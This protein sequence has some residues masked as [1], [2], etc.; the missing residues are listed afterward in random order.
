MN[1]PRVLEK[2]RS[3][4]NNEIKSIIECHDLPLY[5]MMRYHLGWIDEKCNLVN[6]NSGK[7]LRPT[8]CLYSC[9]AVGGDYRKALPAA[10]ALELVHN[11]SLI[12]DD[13][14]DD[15]RE[16]RHRPTV[17]AVWGKPQAINAGTAM[18]ILANFA[19]ER[20]QR[21]N[22][23]QQKQF[24]LY[25]QLD[26]I[27]LKLIEGQYLD[28]D[29]ENRF[30]ITI[31][32]YLEMIDKKTATLISGSMSIGASLGT[33]KESTVEYFG[34]IGK[35]LGLAFQIKDDLLGIWGKERETGKP[36]GNDIKR[37]KKSFPMVFAMENVDLTAR[38]ELIDIYQRQ[39]ISDDDVNEVLEIFE[40][41]N[42]RENTQKQVEIFALKAGQM[43]ANLGINHTAKHDMDKIIE[44]ITER[45]Y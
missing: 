11:F 13:V 3:A 1:S 2:Y 23:S 26:N 29:Y 14:Q 45:N 34:D 18:R 8:L 6:N 22:I 32:N 30:D 43:F 38:N 28:I 24:S 33:E 25:R 35:K 42:T 15:D 40:A 5:N 7:A 36:S 21:C 37:R 10:A 17:W 20:L 39:T 9:E 44:F 41:V 31:G 12:H 4:I 19:L 27:S 16:R